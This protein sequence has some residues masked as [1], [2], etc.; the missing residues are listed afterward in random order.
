MSSTVVPG[1]VVSATVVP[2]M[3]MCGGYL[4]SGGLRA[5]GLQAGQGTPLV[6]LASPLVRAR[7]YIPTVRQLATYFDVTALELPGTGFS[8]SNAKR[9]ELSEHADWIA[10][11]LRELYVERVVLVG[12]SNSGAIVLHVAAKY[13]ELLRGVVIADTVGMRQGCSAVE[14][15]GGRAVDSVLEPALTLRGW[16]DLLYNLVYHPRNFAHQVW[17]AVTADVRAVAERVRV[18]V[19]LAW[20]GSDH[21]VRLRD[22]CALRSLLREC[23]LYVSGGSHDW[24][25]VRA[26]EFAEVVSAWHE[27]TVSALSGGNV[28]RVQSGGR[29]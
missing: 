23:D 14:I 16:P 11:W 3:E 24:L 19:L 22:A 10:A 2:I 1:Q 7:T 21:T 12:H 17:L 8:R 6:L 9:W 18:P 15:L 28:S 26:Q 13:P 29:G 4:G 27:D 5:Y 20:G 25:I